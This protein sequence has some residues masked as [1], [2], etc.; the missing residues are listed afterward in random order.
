MEGVSVEGRMSMSRRF[1]T[2]LTVFDVLFTF[3]IWIICTVVSGEKA[4]NIAFKNEVIN[5]TIGTS[6]FDVVVLA[7]ARLLLIA[8]FY[9]FI[10]ISHWWLIAVTTTGTT[11]FIIA[12][13]FL[14]EWAHS[15]STT[16]SVVL[17][18]CSFILSWGE[19]WFLDFRVF[20]S[21]SKAL[22]FLARYDEE[23][24]P[25]LAHP[26]LS[27]SQ[28]DDGSAFYSPPGS[29]GEDNGKDHD[30]STVSEVEWLSPKN[31]KE[32]PSNSNLEQLPGTS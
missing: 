12:K 6:M 31:S 7:V 9:V 17:L 29:D 2:L 27:R 32:L 22:E 24:A 16:A 15:H 1:F 3:L 10:R 4:I 18:L 14:Y 25:V 23:R 13:V 8:L 5:Y 11:I 21:E 28:S 19:A 30:G 26:N 20:P